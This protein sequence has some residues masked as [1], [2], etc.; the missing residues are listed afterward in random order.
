M[1]DKQLLIDLK[2]Y[3][4]RHT[5]PLK[6]YNR[7]IENFCLLDVIECLETDE[8]EGFIETQRE[9]SFYE[10]LCSYIDKKGV[11][12][13]YIYKKAGIDRRHFSKIRK[14]DYRIRKNTAVALALALELNQDESD[15]LLC[16]AGYSLSRND[17]FDLIIQFFLEKRIYDI[18]TI[19]LALD[20]FSLKPLSVDL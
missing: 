7:D 18:Y 19:N 12:D 8:L 3:V 14:P 9:P 10:I 16:A 20:N 15:E 17:N 2:E 11:A 5:D 6:L 1:L 4:E 13:S